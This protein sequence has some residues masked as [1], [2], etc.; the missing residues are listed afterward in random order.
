MSNIDLVKKAAKEHR[1]RNFNHVAKSTYKPAEQK[2]K[3]LDIKIGRKQAEG[4]NTALY[5][6]QGLSRMYKR[7]NL[8]LKIF[9]NHETK[10]GY[11]GVMGESNIV[12][13]T[14]VQ[15]LL[16]LRG[17]APRVYEL[18]TVNGKTAQVTDFIEGSDKPVPIKDPRFTF[19]EHELE[20]PNNF[21]K[22]QLVDFQ[23]AIFKDYNK[24]KHL[25]LNKAHTHTSF[26]RTERQLYQ[27]T[28][29]CTGKRETKQRL[30]QYKFEDFTGKTILDIGCNL[31]MLMRAAYDG[32]AVRVVGIDWP[33]MIEVSRKMAIMDGYFN[34]DF[35]GVD[36]K[37]ATWEEI[38][39][40]TG[41]EK[42]NIHFFFAMEMWVGWPEWVRNCERVY[43]EGHGHVRPYEV[44]DQ[45]EK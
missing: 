13:S 1:I 38:Q 23:G 21:I 29:Y 42:F 20:R 44:Q 40:I 5:R 11:S 10:W 27:T 2:L 35:A 33:D 45:K 39:K 22:G 12:E 30:G 7:K 14:I 26:P 17:L 3:K 24:T 9:K 34:L 18:V 16:H 43:Y 8:C 19:V 15:N 41:M 37:K 25:L 4:Q 36:I 32:G 6:P 28:E 31:G